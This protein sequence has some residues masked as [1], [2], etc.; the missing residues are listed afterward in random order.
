MKWNLKFGFSVA[1]ATA[2]VLKTST[3]HMGLG[4]TALAVQI[5]NLWTVSES[6]TGQGGSARL[7]RHR[8]LRTRLLV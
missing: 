7:A 5:W 3:S 8:L 1:L 2:E 6:S 4:A